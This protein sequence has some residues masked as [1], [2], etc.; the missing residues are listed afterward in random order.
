M[1]SIIII[2]YN[3]SLDTIECLESLRNSDNTNFQIILVDNNSTDDSVKKLDFYFEKVFREINTNVNQKSTSERVRQFSGINT[4]IELSFII[5]PT[6]VGFAGGNN[7]AINYLLNYE[8]INDEDK[9]FLLNPDTI[10]QEDCINELNMIGKDTFIAGCRIVGYE[11]PN[12]DYFGAYKFKPFTCK[13]NRISDSNTKSEDID[14]IHGGAL[15]TN[16]R[17]IK[18][19]GVLP[20]EYFLYWEETDWCTMAK[21]AGVP[22]VICPSAIVY[23]K[24]GK[25][26]GRGFLA[27]Y[28]F[29]RNGMIFY[30]KYYPHFMLNIFV[31]LAFLI[32]VKIIKGQP[33]VAQGLYRGLM[34]YYFGRTGQKIKIVG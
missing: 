8:F 12:L 23:D 33:R 18:K 32:L 2:N 10:I 29:A 17:T 26:I 25:S 19:I 3:C 28:Y 9:I 24:V 22:L 13:L 34:E 7:I 31:Y 1:F 27:H 4:K 6:N 5:S 21:R 11:N 30:K 15:L 20:S 14:Y 16:V